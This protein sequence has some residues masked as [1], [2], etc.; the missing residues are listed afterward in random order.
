MAIYSA[1]IL[2]ITIFF[3]QRTPGAGFLNFLK[4]LRIFLIFFLIMVA[5]RSFN[6]E[7]KTF[8][9]G[10]SLPGLINGLVFSWRLTMALFV[11]QLFALTADPMDIRQGIYRIL[12]HLPFVPAGRIATMFGLTIAF[13]PLVFDQY[14]EVKAAYLSRLGNLC[15][16]PLKK[17]NALASPLLE[18]VL[19]RAEEI[20]DA[21]ESRCY[22][23]EGDNSELKF[24][25]MDLFA[26]IIFGALTLVVFLKRFF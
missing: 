20:T 7:G 9:G 3:C 18:M 19:R 2:F 16:N 5:A 22:S 13:I 15:K 21:M 25:I 24:K 12:K 4:G 8:L 14:K 10:F 6:G 17:I 11:G 23:D 1:F 26:V